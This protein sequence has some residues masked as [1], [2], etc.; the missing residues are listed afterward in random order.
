MSHA[1]ECSPRA[2]VVKMISRPR[3]LGQD[4][5]VAYLRSAMAPVPSVESR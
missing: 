3:R 1:G 4:R 5:G 2:K